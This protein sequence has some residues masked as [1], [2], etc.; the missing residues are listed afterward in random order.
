VAHPLHSLEDLREQL[1]LAEESRA[2]WAAQGEHWT[3][4]IAET[5]ADAV[6][7]Y[8]SLIAEKVALGEVA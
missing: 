8:R 3:A 4:K 2:F 7:L 6:A 5:S 1:K